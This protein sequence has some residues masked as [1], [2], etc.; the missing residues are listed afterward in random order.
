[1]GYRGDRLLLSDS[2]GCRLE[3]KAGPIRSGS[4]G[5]RSADLLLLERS[6][7]GGGG[8]LLLY[9]LWR[10]DRANPG[11]AGTD[12]EGK[13]CSGG[14]SL[15]VLPGALAA[16]RTTAGSGFPAHTAILSPASTGTAL[17]C[18]A[19]PCSHTYRKRERPETPSNDL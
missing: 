7:G 14:G 4:A 12:G 5:S 13:Q 2:G 9:L 1:Y 3:T 6:L 17:S 19:N 18:S 11:C 10:A 16:H 8:Y 15:P